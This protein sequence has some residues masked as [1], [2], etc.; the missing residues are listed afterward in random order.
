MTGVLVPRQLLCVVIRFNS[1][2]GISES[3]KMENLC[4]PAGK[5]DWK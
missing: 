1:D 2:C 5:G 4:P 3:A